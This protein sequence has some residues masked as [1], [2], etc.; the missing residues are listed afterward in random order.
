MELTKFGKLV[1]TKRIIES[2]KL[3]EMAELLGVSPSYLSS[4]ETGR[5][6]VPS[7]WPQKISE[8]F[9]M[10]ES[11]L[12]DLVKAVEQHPGVKKVTVKNADEAAL[13]AAFSNKQNELD[14]EQLSFLTEFIESAGRK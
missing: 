6:P 4:V 1:R 13:I 2:M 10:S 8:V 3:G 11:E 12:S 5:K 9:N 14:G 7:E